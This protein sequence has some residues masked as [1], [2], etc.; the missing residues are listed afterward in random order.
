VIPEAVA[1]ETA[2]VETECSVS[3]TEVTEGTTS[4]PRVAVAPEVMVEAHVEAHPTTSMELVVREPEV[5]EATPIRSAPMSEGTSASHG[6][7][8]MLDDDLVD[9]TVIAQNMESMRCVEQLNKVPSRL[10]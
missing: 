8:E 9:P 10:P 3:V 7:L 6:G 4:K 5:Q 1:M 2:T